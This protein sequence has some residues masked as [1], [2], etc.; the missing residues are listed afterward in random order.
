M[1]LNPLRR[2]L[3]NDIVVLAKENRTTP[4][5]TLLVGVRAGAYYD[6][7][8]RE[9]TASL[10]A[11]VLDR[12]TTSR[13]ASEIADDLDN[14]GAA[15][16]VVAGRHQLT[17]SATC[18]SEDFDAVFAMVADIVQN[19]L[20]DERE[21]ETRRT[22]LLTAI[23]QD[24]DDPGAVAVD[25]AMS[26][27]YPRHPYGRRPRGST[28][29]V[30]LITRDELVDFHRMWFTPE[31]ATVVVVGD[32]DEEEV[33]R[34]SSR[35]FGAWS[36]PRPAEPAVPSVNAPAARDFAVTPMMNKAQVDIAYAFVGV[37]RADPEY[38]A[39]WV[40]NNALGQYA[41][42]G[43]LGDSIREK[44]GMAYYVY[45]SLDAS[46]AEGPLMIRAG[47]SSGD[48]ERT[49]TSIDQEIV[50]VRD[51]G[52]TEKE[53]GESKRYLIGSIPRQLETNSGIAGFLLSAEFHGLGP[54]YDGL[55]PGKIE[56]VSLVDAHR[57]AARL[58]DPARAEVA[59]AGPWRPPASGEAVA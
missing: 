47:V 15:L 17:V 20:F 9:G 46:L 39:A 1:G 33:V 32:V 51:G 54:D 27:L 31:G 13:S 16:S 38:Y 59:V 34:A 2:T 53:I 12:G 50:H 3:A 45:S 24:E 29:S 52:L 8:G 41:L 21:V 36:Q 10:V 7:D 58:L 43:R 30:S 19:P 55:L 22:E 40:M 11:R 14:R 48:V 6:P 28:Q 49:V 25:L 44:Q 56:A 57:I 23:L 4:A 35:A 37:R 5:V 18:L 26:R 42:G